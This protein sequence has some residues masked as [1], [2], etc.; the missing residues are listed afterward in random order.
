MELFKAFLKLIRL[1]NLLMIAAS[2][3][4]MHFCIIKPLLYSY[5]FQSQ[6]ATETLI[7]LVLATVCI[8]A[9]GYAIN[10]YFDLKIDLLNKPSKVVVSKQ[11]NRRAVMLWHLI[12]SGIGIIL[13]VYAS[14]KSGQI[15]LSVIFLLIAGLLWFYSTTYKRQLIIGN[16]V[17]AVIVGLVPFIVALFEIPAV[18]DE[19]REI[20]INNNNAVVIHKILYW[21]MGFSFFAFITNLTREII[22]DIEDFEGDRAYGA[23]SIV[24]M[25]GV[26][27]AKI[28]S[29]V[30]LLLTILSIVFIY[31][32]FLM[33]TYDGVIEFRSIIYL[34]LL[35]ILPLILA[36]IS[37]FRARNAGQYHRVAMFLKFVM[38]TGMFFSIVL[39]FLF[40]NAT[41]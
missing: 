14:F 23:K 19:Y 33:I 13:G 10:D 6:L 15:Y 35:V 29:V 31:L 7:A 27:T 20:M 4:L 16:L 21:I 38:F 32:R 24:I 26:K 5:G 18:I 37:L 2:Q 41:Y 40:R 17:I 12:F 1:P 25:W 36:V 9:G 8:A 11:I 30:L 22:K 3:L 34:G 28:I 39:F